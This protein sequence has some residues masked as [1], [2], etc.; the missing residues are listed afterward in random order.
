[1]AEHLGHH[2]HVDPA[3]EREGGRAVAEVVPAPQDLRAEL[4]AA[5]EAFA[6]AQR[7]QIRADHTAAAGLRQAARD[8]VHAGSGKDGSTLAVLVAALVWAAILSQRWHTAK[9]HA[10]Q[11]EATRRTVQHL[12][13]DYDQAAADQLAFLAQRQ[14]KEQTRNTLASDVRAA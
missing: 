13:A 5:A 7:S 6:C 8:L 4:R 1:M 11:A 14:P 12:Q 2:L 9:G 10:P 3:G